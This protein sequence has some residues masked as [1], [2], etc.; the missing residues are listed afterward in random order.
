MAIGSV[1]NYFGSKDALIE[2]VYAEVAQ[3]MANAIV[4]NFAT[5][6]GHEERIRRYIADYVAFAIADAKRIQLFDYLDNS[7]GLDLESL[8]AVFKPLIDYTSNLLEEAHA[9]AVREGS[10]YLLGTFI[11]GSAR[12]LIKRRRM[13]DPA[14]ITPAEADWIVELC[15]RAIAG[16][17]A[18]G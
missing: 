4:V 12:H 10:T 11:R 2:G 3:Q 9:G 15:W 13:H 1:Y 14:P 17:N 18:E 5:N 6:V 16:H 8:S 7:P